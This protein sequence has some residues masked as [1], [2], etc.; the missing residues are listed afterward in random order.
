MINNSCGDKSIFEY[1]IG[2]EQKI[3]FDFMFW[4]LVVSV[5]YLNLR[6]LKYRFISNR[7]VRLSLSFTYF[8]TYGISIYMVMK[9]MTFQMVG[10]LS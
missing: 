2:L 9:M 1:L 3:A 4:P 6:G 5:F 10:S 7:L 8:Y